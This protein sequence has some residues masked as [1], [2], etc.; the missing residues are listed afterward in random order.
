MAHDIYI[1]I[2]I[3]ET[4][5]RERERYR[6]RELVSYIYIC[7]YFLIVVHTWSIQFT[8]KPLYTYIH[9]RT[10]TCI[11]HQQTLSCVVDPSRLTVLAPTMALE[12]ILDAV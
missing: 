5:E 4:R 11:L 3:F 6:D 7:I 8:V 1:Y 10:G 9:L 12:E 2:Y